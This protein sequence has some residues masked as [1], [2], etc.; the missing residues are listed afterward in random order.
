MLEFLKPFRVELAI[1]LLFTL[2]GSHLWAYS[3]G[4]HAER[5]RWQ[6]VQV[7]EAVDRAAQEAKNKKETERRYNEQVTIANKATKQ[8]TQAQADADD[9]RAAGDRLR[10]KVRDL[11]LSLALRDPTTPAGGEAAADTIT[12]LGIVQQRLDGAAEQLARYAD[13]A[14]TAGR[15]CEASYDTLT[16][17][18]D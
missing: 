14:G 15:A 6:I 4:V 1:G 11:N 12:L 10:A 13:E 2:I 3:K 8:L 7:E 17:G 5:N 9:A 18:K 16:E